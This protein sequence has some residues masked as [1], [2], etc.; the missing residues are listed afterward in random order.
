MPDR[1]VAEHI[2]GFCIDLEGHAAQC[3]PAGFFG[4]RRFA[5]D[6]VGLGQ[7]DKPVETGFESP[8]DWAQLTVP[9]REI[10]LQAQRQQR[11]HA[12]IADARGFA[13]RHDLAIE[14]VLIFWRHPDFVAEVAGVGDAVDHRGHV[15]DVHGTVRHE[16]EGGVRDVLVGQASQH[17]AR[18]RP[19][20]G[21]ADQVQVITAD[22]NVC[23]SEGVRPLQRRGLTP[24]LLEP[25]HMILL[26]LARS[27]HDKAI[28]GRFGDGKIADQFAV[29][30]Q[31]RRQ[32]QPA[33]LRHLVGHQPRQERLGARSGKLILREIRDLRDA[34]AVA[35][36]TALVADML[37]VVRAV[38][39]HDVLGLRPLGCEPQRHLKPPR[40]AHHGAL[41]AHDIVERRRL[42]RPRGRQFFVRKADGEAARIILAHFF[43]RVRPCRPFAV[44]RHVH[45]PDIEAGIAV[46]HPLREGEADTAALAESRHDSAGDPEIPEPLHRPHQWVAVRRERERTID[47]ALDAGLGHARKMLVGDLQRGGD[48]VEIIGQE[49]LAEIPGRG[50]GLPGPAVLLVG[51]QNHAVALLAHVNFRLE[52]ERVAHLL[53]VLLVVGDDLGNI[54]G[55]HIHVLHGQHR[56]L[57]ADHAANFSRPQAA[58]VHNMLGDNDALLGDDIPGTV[59]ARLKFHHA[60]VEVDLRPADLGRLGVGLGGAFGIE[61]AVDLVVERADKVLLLHQ[62]KELLG[63]RR[64]QQ[65][66]LKVQIAGPRV[67]HLEEVHAVV[68]VG[69]D[70]AARAM[71]PATLPGDLLELIVQTDRVALQLGHVRIAVQRVETARRVPGRSRRQPR[72]LNQHDVFPACLGEMVQHRTADDAAADDRDLGVGF[73]GDSIS[74]EWFE[75]A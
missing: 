21:E 64:R 32:D 73:H 13:R 3:T 48:A 29:R 44:A 45:A 37:E 43:V 46:D 9:G 50:L 72:A 71:Q 19:G 56:Q 41:S 40:I 2:G 51:A 75:L 1:L 38:E 39:R 18:L 59:W 24:Y 57:N 34:D 22:M 63:F 62:W 11:P 5:A 55:H 68:G 52:V 49:L 30:V 20:D 33:R 54:L 12:E 47:H 35:H 15:A 7:I 70:D 67:G 66:G 6:E 61:I 10:L 58:A 28:I 53:A 69:Q 26:R 14:P 23:C 27:P 25:A 16:G 65:L 60:V 8:V 36:Q 74:N 31:H 42:L 4:C 17:L